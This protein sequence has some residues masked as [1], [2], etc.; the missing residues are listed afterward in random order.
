MGEDLKKKGEEEEEDEEEKEEVEEEN[1]NH[2]IT[3]S[4]CCTSP[5]QLRVTKPRLERR[6]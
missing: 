2:H 4:P 1:R 3:V 5:I 6:N